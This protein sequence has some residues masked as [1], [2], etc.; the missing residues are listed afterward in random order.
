MPFWRGAP[1]H[2]G[3][4]QGEKDMVNCSAIYSNAQYASSKTE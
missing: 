3:A 2:Q 4:V 1:H